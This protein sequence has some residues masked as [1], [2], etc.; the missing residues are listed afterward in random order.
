MSTTSNS[1]ADLRSAAAAVLLLL[2]A[3]ATTRPAADPEAPRP[4][5]AAAATKPP[6]AVATPDRPDSEAPIEVERATVRPAAEVPEVLARLRR[7][8]EETSR[9]AVID[10]TTSVDVMEQRSAYPVIVL[11]GRQLTDTLTLGPRRLAALVET[12]AL[13]GESSVT[14]TMI[15]DPS[16]TSRRAVTLRAP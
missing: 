10:V 4:A 8:G 16:R 13:R 6:R 2:A 14:V 7:G 11:N 1:R 3:C 15:G 5:L 9:L 12:A